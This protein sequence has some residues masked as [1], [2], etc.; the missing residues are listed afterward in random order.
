MA[1]CLVGCVE[2]YLCAA[3]KAPQPS[4]VI[5]P[6]AKV[7]F[8]DPNNP[9]ITVGNESSP[10]YNN[11]AGIHS[12]QTGMSDGFGCKV[13]IIDQ[14]GGSFQLFVDKMLK[15]MAKSRESY[16]MG[17][18]FGWVLASCGGSGGAG[19]VSSRPM[20]F[21]PQNLDISYSNGC[22]MFTITGIDL[23]QAVFVARHDEIKGDDV[24]KMPLK[25]AIIDL[26]QKSNPKFD[27]VFY[28]R[29]NDS[30]VP[31]KFKE[32][33]ENGPEAKWECDGQNKLATIRKWIEPYRTD[34][35]KGIIAF[36]G[37]ATFKEPTLVLMEDPQESG[38]KC[39]AESLGTFI[40]NG[41]KCSNVIEFNP[42]INFVAAWGGLGSGGMVGGA[43]T[44]ETLEKPEKENG[45]SKET[46]IQQSGSIHQS[47]YNVHG[48]KNASK[49]Y[50]KSQQAHN[51]ANL[52][53]NNVITGELRIQGDPTPEFVQTPLW[54]GKSVSIVVI[55]PFHLSGTGF[56]GTWLANPGCNDVLTN[57]KWLIRGI[58]HKIEPSTGTY[59]TI[60]KV[61]LLGPGINTD[62]GNP[63]G[64][65]GSGGYTPEN[66]C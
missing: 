26:G 2:D 51:K 18:E 17:I 6:F 14:E 64:G 66:L 29:E 60:L 45:E 46:G 38:D 5:S 48:P 41:G 21:S 27:V 63:L 31:F 44:G 7:F 50:Q 15:C 37:G 20:Y 32:G 42:A 24:Q 1:N 61:E 54:M 62:K 52:H 47:A 30:F 58:E 25:Q 28:R 19:V 35:D 10:K 40:V 4:H 16:R 36:W 8:G 23:M 43:G 65:P 49:E 9:E 12:L 34:K 57:K 11:T 53:H 3:L 56:C 13:E 22:I 33:G 39:E 59:E 55:N